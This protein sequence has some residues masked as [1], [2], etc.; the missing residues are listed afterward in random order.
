MGSAD[1]FKALTQGLEGQ[2]ATGEVRLTPYLS[3]VVA[4][5]FL[6]TADGEIS[7]RDS[8]KLQSAIGADAEVLGRA[9][10]YVRQHSLERFLHDLAGLLDARDR[11]CLLINVGDLLMVDGEFP[12]PR[13]KHFERLLATLGTTKA[14]FQSYFNTVAIKGRTSVL[15]DFS[16]GSE[17]R[18]LTPPMA[19][20]VA[21]AHMLSSNGSPGESEVRQAGAAHGASLALLDACLS[22]IR[23]L[24]G[25]GF[26]L[27]AS[28]VL[29]QRQR[30]CLLANAADT[31][32]ADQTTSSSRRVFFRRMLTAFDVNGKDF[33]RHLNVFH[34]K[35]DLP[36]DDVDGRQA[37]APL[38][39]SSRSSEK[40]E[41]WVFKRERHWTEETGEAGST[42][43]QASGDAIK[44][45]LSDTAGSAEPAGSE[46]SG[47]P[48]IGAISNSQ[49]KGPV[50]APSE[51]PRPA[52]ATSA[53][54]KGSPA[55]PFDVRSLSDTQAGAG[56]P[57]RT[58]AG[59]WRA[60]PH[61]QDADA[62]GDL[63]EMKDG[64]GAEDQRRM[65]DQSSASAGRSLVDDRRSPE[66]DRDTGK[67]AVPADSV[68][69]RM[70][71]AGDR[72][73]V[74][75]AHFDA[76]ESVKSL[77]EAIRLPTLPALRTAVSPDAV[78]GGGAGT[79]TEI[80]PESRMKARAAPEADPPMLEGTVIA[81]ADAEMP[82][83]AEAND[84]QGDGNY[85]L[86]A[87]DE[88]GPIMDGGT[89]R[90]SN[91][92]VRANQRLRRWSAALLPA[93]SLTIGTSMMGEGMA[94]RAFVT[95]E[96]LATDAHIV[97]QMA[98]VQQ[99][100][101]RMVPD[102]VLPVADGLQ[103]AAAPMIGS[104][105]A[106]AAAAGAVAATS[107]HSDPENL[108]EREKADRFLE[109][110]K[111]ELNGVFRREQKASVQAAERQQWFGYAKAMALLGL[112]M[113]FWGMLF[114][115]MRSLHGATAIG[116]ASLLLTLNGFWPIIRF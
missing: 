8:G 71:A 63:R 97:H 16:A 70:Q 79:A 42:G 114:R 98:S 1:L 31:M 43:G 86:L 15:G 73:R 52:E 102:A 111:Q 6:M 83:G 103:A 55:G 3:I 18:A 28:L 22:S 81:G 7:E 24:R 95:S 116:L 57:L 23:Q 58:V 49:G 13:L 65:T 11:L 74:L 75:H 72:T 110:R 21:Q 38:Q 59:L 37:A 109:N 47:E 87:S 61:L 69:R 76:M 84:E 27:Q 115:S 54:F 93:L 41:G 88:G 17:S 30:L 44:R 67:S 80:R 50:S 62:S 32:M 112:V 77:Q 113:A 92:E 40:R 78:T 10:G 26:L 100:I 34:L 14:G 2:A 29:D 51:R 12:A 36:P 82:A 90:A 60:R 108:S 33:D 106:A 64:S 20:L 39:R 96:N 101:Y 25:S 45:R 48:G 89:T 99:T 85:M 91:E 9:V 5:L 105:G 94:E 68:A 46:R 19:L 53:T 35:N 107:T 66:A 4:S 104:A 56:T